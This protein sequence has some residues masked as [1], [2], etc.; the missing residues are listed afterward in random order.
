MQQPSDATFY[1]AYVG[2]MIARKQTICQDSTSSSAGLFLM[3]ES[4][5][6]S[7]MIA[8]L[9]GVLF[10][11]RASGATPDADAVDNARQL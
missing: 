9:E 6:T 4:A 10:P 7:L 3:F 5:L 8:P 2:H 1:R 11:I